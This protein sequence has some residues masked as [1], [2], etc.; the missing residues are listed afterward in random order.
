MMR[1]LRLYVCESKNRKDITEPGVTLYE[2][3]PDNLVHRYAQFGV[4]GSVFS[5][6]NVLMRA[7]ISPD[8]MAAHPAGEEIDEI[9]FAASWDTVKNM[10]QLCRMMPDPEAPWSKTATL[11]NGETAFLKWVPS[12]IAP[13]TMWM[14]VPGF[15]RL[16]ALTSDKKVVRR[17][18]NHIF[19]GGG[20][21]LFDSIKLRN[22][23]E[24]K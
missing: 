18:Y 11:E 24:A 7:G 9:E 12:G 19:L 3:A 1:Y 10:R 14:R 15:E 5:P 20:A 6:E 23:Q 2:V 17:I 4:S 13:G 8:Y 16:F 21:D 22:F